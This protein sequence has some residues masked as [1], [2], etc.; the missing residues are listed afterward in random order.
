[1]RL[2]DLAA[3]IPGAR[4]VGDPNAEIERA[5]LDSR[6]VQAGDIFVAMRRQTVDSADF[7]ADALAGGAAAVAADRILDLPGGTPQLIVPD[8]RHALG[9]IASTLLGNPSEQLRLVGVT[10]TDGKT[11]TSRLIAAVLAASGRR[12]GWITTAEMGLGERIEPSPFVRTTPEPW[13]LQEAL[14]QMVAAGAEDAVVEVSSHALALDR[15][16]GCRFDAAVFTNLAPEHL[17]FHGTMEAY[18]EAKSRLF[19]LLDSPTDKRWSRM[20]VV[21]AD[22]PASLVMVGASPAAIVSYALETPADVMATNIEIRPDGTRFTLVTPLGEA[23]LSTRFAGRHNVYNWLAAA[24]LGLGW[25][26]DIAA[27]VKAAEETL[28]PPGRLQRVEHGQPFAVVVDFAHTPQAL[29]ATLR[30]LREITRGGLYLLFGMAGR[31]D[32]SNRPTMGQLAAQGTD[33]FI[34]SMDD[35][36][37]EDPAAIAQQVA[38]GARGGGAIE[39]ESFVVQ[40]DR[41]QAIQSLF[42]R[43]RAGDTVLLAGKGHENRMLLSDVSEPWSDVDVAR[44]VLIQLGYSG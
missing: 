3:A 12:V 43:A 10:G 34:I 18:A 29:A 9:E 1:M 15:V 41:R 24:A 35:P 39:G 26:I 2:G 31:R 19:A 20:G 13:D 38:S 7:A 33:F 25:G 8:P 37:D 28:P 4:V 11:T 17:D 14:Q 40:L 42:D 27:V 32:P 23:R 21:N 44:E 6:Q 5:A 30:T 36:L 16:A 22:D